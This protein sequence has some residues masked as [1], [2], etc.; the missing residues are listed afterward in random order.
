MKRFLSGLLGVLMLLP[1]YVQAATVHKHDTAVSVTA[2]I[3]A[4]TTQ[5]QGQGALVTEV[6]EISTVANDGDT[7]TLPSAIAGIMVLVINNGINTLQ[8]F[9]ASGDNLGA[10]ANASEELEASE[11]VE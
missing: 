3:T 2:G 1:V 4:S 11:A 8:I 7:V 10:G 6:N 5:S 9:P